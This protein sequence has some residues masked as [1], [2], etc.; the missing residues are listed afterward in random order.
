MLRTL[1][2]HV[3]P[4]YNPNTQL[5]SSD[6][7]HVIVGTPHATKLDFTSLSFLDPRHQMGISEMPPRLIKFTINTEQFKYTHKLAEQGGNGTVYCFSSHKSHILVKTTPL[8]RRYGQ[9]LTNNPILQQV[10]AQA[11]ELV[12]YTYLCHNGTTHVMERGCGDVLTLYNSMAYDMIVPFVQFCVRVGRFFLDHN[13][14][15]PDYKLEN[16]IYF[17]DDPAHTLAF[18]L[19]DL[20]SIIFADNVPPT[21]VITNIMPL[22][23]HNPEDVN[24]YPQ[25]YWYGQYRRDSEDMDSTA[26]GNK[27]EL[28]MLAHTVY[29]ILHSIDSVMSTKWTWSTQYVKHVHGYI[30]HKPTHALNAADKKRLCEYSYQLYTHIHAIITGSIPRHTNL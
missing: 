4:T 15:C 25:L 5:A 27:Y 20:E 8:L 9:D 6:M 26:L 22:S 13:V 2:K 7:P 16:V 19:I 28:Y 12:A 29:S 10:M 3:L 14:A 30:L 23:L 24:P 21:V 1:A 17:I 11:P 18:R